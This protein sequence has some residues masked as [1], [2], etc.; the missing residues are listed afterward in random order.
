M[1]SQR[2]FLLYNW[3]KNT[4]VYPFTLNNIICY[5]SDAEK[6]C[7]Y[8]HIM[9]ELHKTFQYGK[10]KKSSLLFCLQK[11]EEQSDVIRTTN[12]HYVAC[13]I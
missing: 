7:H 11:L 10:I 8:M 5:F 4:E 9:D 12:V 2:L 6:G 1:K 13:N 3:S